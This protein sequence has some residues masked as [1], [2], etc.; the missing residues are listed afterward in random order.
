M[1]FESPATFDASGLDAQDALYGHNVKIGTPGSMGTPALGAYSE[2]ASSKRL[3]EGGLVPD[4]FDCTLRLRKSVW[5]AF[6]TAEHFEGKRVEVQ[7]GAA[8][9]AYRVVIA[10]DC[11][12]TGEW[13][14]TLNAI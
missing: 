2:P 10:Q 4:G 7:L 14:V 3:R 9:Q 1:S 13:R 6:T 8:W 5:T 12:H 11:H